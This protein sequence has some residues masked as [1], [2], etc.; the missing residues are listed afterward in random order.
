MIIYGRLCVRQQQQQHHIGTTEDDHDHN[1]M[2]GHHQQ[3]CDDNDDKHR[4]LKTYLCL[5][6]RYVYFILFLYYT[7]VFLQLDYM[8][9]NHNHNH[10]TNE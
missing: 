5:G 10:M 9:T 2:T 4:G 1:M 7:N 8:Y 6:P 3:L